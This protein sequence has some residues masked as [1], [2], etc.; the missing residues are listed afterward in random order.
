[1][2]KQ[3]ENIIIKISLTVILLALGFALYFWMNHKSYELQYLMLSGICI[4]TAIMTSLSL[5]T[6]VGW[7]R[8]TVSNQAVM[9]E[10]ANE[11]ETINMLLSESKAMMW[12]IT[13]NNINLYAAPSSDVHRTQFTVDDFA[14]VVHPDDIPKYQEFIDFARQ[15]V[16]HKHQRIRLSLT[17]RESWHWFDFVYTITLENKRQRSMQGICVNIDEYVANENRMIKAEQRASEIEAKEHFIVNIGDDLNTPLDAVVGFSQVLANDDGTMTEAERKE[18]ANVIH[19]NTDALLTI[20]NKVA[21]E[22]LS[23]REV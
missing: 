6:I 16:G 7:H 21:F 5:V 1:M 2:N 3:S 9:H 22:S 14:H 23:L 8:Y 18:L 19:E 4:L 12:N 13:G 17:E 10:L 15:E 11:A 20:I